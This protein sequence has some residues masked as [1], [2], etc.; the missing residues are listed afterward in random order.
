LYC[1]YGRR[2]DSLCEQD[3]PVD[4]SDCTILQ[5]TLNRCTLSDYNIYTYEIKLKMPSPFW[6]LVPEVKLILS[7]EFK[8]FT[9][10]IKP[11]DQIWFKGTLFNNQSAGPNGILGSL[12]TYVNA[13]EIG[14]ISCFDHELSSFKAYTNN[15]FNFK[16]V[17][18]LYDGFK[19]LLNVMFNPVLVF[20]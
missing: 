6:S 11:K 18:R 13:H 8:N 10:R 7:D 5:K 3:N 12:T 9:L 1:V 20:K 14:C 17:F 2:T 16:Y 19:F 4:I 15:G